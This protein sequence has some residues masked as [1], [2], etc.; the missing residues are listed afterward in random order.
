V[1]L[2]TGRYFD[3]RV[4]R[5][6]LV[7]IGITAYPP[8]K[9]WYELRANLRELAPDPW[10]R[11]LARDAFERRYRAKLDALGVRCVHDLIGGLAG[12]QD[13][14][15]LCYEDV[16]RAGVWCHSQCLRHGGRNK[17]EWLCPSWSKRT[18]P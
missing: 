4:P 12:D 3:G 16:R 11:N 1:K 14:V 18:R 2:Y 8:S 13:A 7:P 10:M 9:L 15:L 17:P 5:S 6:G